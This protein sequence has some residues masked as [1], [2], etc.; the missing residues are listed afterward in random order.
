MPHDSL[1]AS[2]YE[3]SKARS[4]GQRGLKSELFQSKTP[5][6]RESTNASEVE[7][8]ALNTPVMSHG[9]GA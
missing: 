8:P 1:L 5:G 2:E 7:A 6:Y 9:I 3:E 4:K